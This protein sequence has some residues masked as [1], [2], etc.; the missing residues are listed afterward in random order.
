[1]AYGKDLTAKILL[2]E[3]KALPPN[4]INISN[5]P[6]S[7]ETYFIVKVSEKVYISDQVREVISFL[8]RYKKVFKQLRANIKIEEMGLYFK[9]ESGRTKPKDFFF[10]DE[11]VSLA[12]EIGI[13]LN[14]YEDN[15]PTKLFNCI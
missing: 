1:M 15:L 3:L 5:T 11:L 4:L 2:E 8:S 9:I 12:L 13:H 14:L 10:P 6:M 7:I